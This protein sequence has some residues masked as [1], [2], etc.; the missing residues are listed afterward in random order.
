MASFIEGIVKGF[1]GIIVQVLYQIT[2]FFHEMSNGFYFISNH[3]NISWL[4]TTLLSVFAFSAGI[5]VFF[6]R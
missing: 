3:T 4:R 6:L 5:Y 1:Y 2:K